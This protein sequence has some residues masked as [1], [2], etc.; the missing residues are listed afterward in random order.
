VEVEI[1]RAFRGLLFLQVGGGD[2][3][4]GEK[5]SDFGDSGEASFLSG[6]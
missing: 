6:P 2:L 4:V 3:A 5:P 1:A